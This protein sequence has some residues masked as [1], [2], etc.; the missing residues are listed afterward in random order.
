[1]PDERVEP[2]DVHWLAHVPLQ[3]PLQLVLPAPDDTE[4]VPL[5]PLGNELGLV[6]LH[7][8][9]GGSEITPVRGLVALARVERS[10]R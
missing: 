6:R 1:V 4:D 10:R 2:R 7:C 9:E 8:R 3:D 5:E